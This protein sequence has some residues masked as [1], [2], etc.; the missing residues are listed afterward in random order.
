MNY[1]ANEIAYHE[2]HADNLVSLNNGSVSCSICLEEIVLS[3]SQKQF[4]E[5]LLKL[6]HVFNE[7]QLIF[8]M[9][10]NKSNIHQLWRH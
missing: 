5:T 6:I 4:F 3:V 8:H 10:Q 1:R 9:S 2:V 7:S